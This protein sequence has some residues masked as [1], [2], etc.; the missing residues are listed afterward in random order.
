MAQ[1]KQ[2]DDGVFGHPFSHERR[3]VSSPLD[4]KR[5]DDLREGHSTYMQPRL[6]ENKQLLVQVCRFK[7]RLQA[8]G[9][10]KRVGVQ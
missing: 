4:V 10:F 9:T 2:A 7:L 5:G 3:G 6:S 8:D 1:V